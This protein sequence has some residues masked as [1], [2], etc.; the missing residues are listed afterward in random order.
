MSEM[1]RSTIWDKTAGSVPVVTQDLTNPYI[2]LS[3]DLINEEMNGENELIDSFNKGDIKGVIDGLGDVLKVTCQMCYALDI[4]PEDLLKEI[5]D[6]NF[7]KFCINEE[8]AIL[9]VEA[10]RDDPRYKNVFYEKFGNYYIIK[11]YKISDD[12][13]KT[14]PKVLKGIFYREPDLSKFIYKELN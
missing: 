10:Y 14:S 11:G 12:I 2:I 1:K 9:S 6:S 3:I 4:D 5:N 8:H 13:T 7:T